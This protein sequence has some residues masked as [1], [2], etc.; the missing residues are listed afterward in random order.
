[1]L[2]STGYLYWTR[3]EMHYSNAAGFAKKIAELYPID[4][5]TDMRSWAKPLSIFCI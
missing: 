3:G 1:M 5:T 2:V 4:A